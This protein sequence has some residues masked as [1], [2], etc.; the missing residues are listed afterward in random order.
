MFKCGTYKIIFQKRQNLRIEKDGKFDT[1]CY[2]WDDNNPNSVPVFEGTAYINPK[3]Q[4]NKITG[5]KIAL[6][7][8]LID[9]YKYIPI[10]KVKVPVWRFGKRERTEIWAAFWKWVRSWKEQKEGR[11]CP[12]CG[13]NLVLT[14]DCRTYM[15]TNVGHNYSEEA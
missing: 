9:H 15:R 4:C 3:D 6:T 11:I 5:K 7:K 1:T 14:K 2:I 12:E 10:K 8:A 13:R